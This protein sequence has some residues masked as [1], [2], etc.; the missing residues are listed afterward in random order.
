[1]DKSPK[2]CIVGFLSIMAITMV[3]FSSETNSN[4]GKFYGM[5]TLVKYDENRNE[6]F[7]QSV[8][9]QLTDEGETFLLGASFFNGVEHLDNTQI[10]SICLREG[11]ITV[12]ETQT[13]SLFETGNTIATTALTNCIVDSTVDITTTQGLA[14]IGPLTFDEPNHVD[15]GDTVNGIGICQGNSGTTPFDGCDNAS[16]ILFAVID[17]ADVTLAATETVDITYTFNMTSPLT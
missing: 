10:G 16:Q 4:D 11:A 13:A 15:A 17:T 7:S 5:L 14:V 2:I 9:N 6:V 8:H 3:P 12:A 1:M